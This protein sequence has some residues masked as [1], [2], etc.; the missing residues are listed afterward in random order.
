MLAKTMTRKIRPKGIRR[1]P[2]ISV[3]HSSD[4][5]GHLGAPEPGLISIDCISLDFKH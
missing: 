2:I 4:K 5:S 1:G 3:H